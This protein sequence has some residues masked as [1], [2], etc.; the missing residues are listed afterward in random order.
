MHAYKYGCIC[1]S[2]KLLATTG[3]IRERS[4]ARNRFRPCTMIDGN[5]QLA[6]KRVVH[7]VRF[8]KK[9]IGKIQGYEQ[10]TSK[11]ANSKFRRLRVSLNL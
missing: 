3:P 10:L 11:R 4:R 8:Q 9:S 1:I 7:A 5:M 6:K 2:G